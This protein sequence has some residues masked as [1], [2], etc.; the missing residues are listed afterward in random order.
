MTFTKEQIQKAYKKLSPEVQDFVMSNETTDTIEDLLKN[1]GL[2]DELLDLA[3]VEIL[4]AM[5]G[6]QTLDES[7]HQIS[8][9]S[10]Q[11]YNSLLKLK[12]SLSTNIFSEIDNLKIDYNKNNLKTIKPSD[13]KEKVEEISKKYT[14]SEAQNDILIELAL[15]T[16]NNIDS[17]SVIKDTIKQRLNISDLLAEQIMLD[18]DKRVFSYAVKFIES[19]EKTEEKTLS[20]EVSDILNTPEEPTKSTMKDSNGLNHLRSMSGDM[21]SAENGKMEVKPEPKTWLEE[22]KLNNSSKETKPEVSPLEQKIGSAPVN[23]PGVDVSQSPIKTEER[24]IQKPKTQTEFVQRPISVPRYTADLSEKDEGE[25]LLKKSGIFP[26]K[27][28]SEHRP[29]G[30]KPDMTYYKQS[31]KDFPEIKTENTK[32]NSAQETPKKYTSDPYREPIE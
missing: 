17:R 7:I 13:I 10:K 29:V 28:D 22:L 20:S 9:I 31:P 25:Y 2:N 8:Q 18:L 23:L 14:L 5:Y 19:N 16:I 12:N 32:N 1:N 30:L 3:S 4:F 24:E 27:E 11:G 26:E 21:K 6:L 15:Y